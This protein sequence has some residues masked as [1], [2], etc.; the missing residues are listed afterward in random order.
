MIFFLSRC[1]SHP[2]S[3]HVTWMVI[4]SDWTYLPPIFLAQQFRPNSAQSESQLGICR[5]VIPPPVVLVD[6]AGKE[7]GSKGLPVLNISYPLSSFPSLAHYL[8][9]WF[10]FPNG[11]ENWKRTG[12]KELYIYNF[13]ISGIFTALLSILSGQI[14]KPGRLSDLDWKFFRPLAQGVKRCF[15]HAWKSQTKRVFLQFE[16]SWNGIGVLEMSGRER[17]RRGKESETRVEKWIQ[18]PRA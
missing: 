14:G 8:L 3:V 4:A 16:V 11:Q 1:L 15:Q 9:C 6:R 7:D 13:L 17:E 12:Q 10:P 18:I 2:F 5:P